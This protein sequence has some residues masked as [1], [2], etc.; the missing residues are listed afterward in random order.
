MGASR[1]LHIPAFIVWV[2]GLAGLLNQLIGF[3]N[4]LSDLANAII[5]PSTSSIG[6]FVVHGLMVVLG[7]AAHIGIEKMS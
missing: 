6:A 3:T 1:V 5:S 2:I 4:L 7:L